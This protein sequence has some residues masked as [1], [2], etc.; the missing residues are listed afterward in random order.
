M[1]ANY[2]VDNSSHSTLKTQKSRRLAF[3]QKTPRARTLATKWRLRAIA[4]PKFCLTF[5]R[6]SRPKLDSPMQRNERWGARIAPQV[7]KPSEMGARGV[8][9]DEV[10]KYDVVQRYPA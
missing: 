2:I 8:S 10:W 1:A 5:Q 7:P 3:K 6:M 9:C 4:R